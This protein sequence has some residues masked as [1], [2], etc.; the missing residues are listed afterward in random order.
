MAEGAKIAPADL[1]MEAP[2]AKAIARNSG[3]MTYPST[4]LSPAISYRT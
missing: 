3:N 1:E 2:H 4:P